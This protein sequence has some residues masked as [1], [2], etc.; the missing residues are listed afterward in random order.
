MCAQNELLFRRI[1]CFSETIVSLL[2]NLEQ[3]TRYR[4]LS[5]NINIG[6]RKKSLAFH[7]GDWE[8]KYQIVII[9]TD[10]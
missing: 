4:L 10:F 6:I 8:S 2:Q 9:H 5:R 7:E 3:E 1:I